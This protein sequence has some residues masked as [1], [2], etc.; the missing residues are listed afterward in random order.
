LKYEKHKHHPE[1]AKDLVRAIK[2]KSDIDLRSS[3]GRAIKN[4]K[5]A[6]RK[7]LDGTAKVLLERDVANC[8][9][10]QSMLIKNITDNF[11][12]EKGTLNPG[13]QTLLRIQASGRSALLALKKFESKPEGIAGLFGNVPDDE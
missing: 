3:A 4:M 7:D 6:V 2:D 9:V 8:S 5:K 1:T 12:D 13:L 10:I 11:K